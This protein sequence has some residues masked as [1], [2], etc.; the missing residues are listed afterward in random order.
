MENS[1]INFRDLYEKAKNSIGQV[2]ILIAGKTGVGK[3]TLLN[4]IFKEDLAKTGKGEPVTQETK[5]YYKEGSPYHI[6]DTK[7]F[8]LETYH[9]LLDGVKKTIA[10]RKTKDPKTHVHIAWYCIQ[11]GGDRIEESEYNFIRELQKEIPVI[12][13]LTK[14]YGADEIFYNK[15]KGVLFETSI[16]VIPVL[17]APFVGRG[18]TIIPSFGLDNLVKTTDELLPK[19]AKIAFAAAQKIDKELRKKYVTGIIGTAA[20]AAVAAG[21]TPIP[22]SDA[23]A[24]APIQ[25]S[26][27]AGISISMGLEINASFLSTLVASAAGVVGAT[28]AGRAIVS[29]LLKLIPGAGSLVGGIISGATAGA[30]TTAMGWAYYNAID[31]MI[32]SGIEMTPVA[33][34]NTFKKQLLLS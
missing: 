4:A 16:Q 12:V 23:I 27:L 7:G 25:I 31:L 13:V 8:E 20:T 33:I 28:Y 30:L 29:G 9:Q 10:D 22:F 5:E 2:N 18:G 21:A 26:M 6:I 32:D 34:A 15:V 19:A 3:S 14:S 17:A 24:L 1:D 11:D